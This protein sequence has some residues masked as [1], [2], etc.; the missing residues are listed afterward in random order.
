MSWSSSSSSK[1][2]C[3]SSRISSSSSSC[4][5]ATAAAALASATTAV[6]AAIST[7]AFHSGSGIRHEQ[8]PSPAISI[9][10]SPT[11]RVIDDEGDQ[12]IKAERDAERLGDQ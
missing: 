11:V 5:A 7:Q 10:T 9:H 12:K 1:T 8:Q 6:A 3:S 4:V 2:M